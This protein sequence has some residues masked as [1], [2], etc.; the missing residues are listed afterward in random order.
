MLAFFDSV[1]PSPLAGQW[2]E[3]DPARLARAVDELLPQVPTSPGVIGLLAPHAGHRYSGPVAAQAYAALRG[4]TPQTVVILSP[5]HA[6]HSAPLLTSAHSAY[7][8]PLGQVP[9]EREFLLRLNAELQARGVP[10]LTP[11]AYDGEHAQEIQLPFLQRALASPFSLAPLMLRQYTPALMR[12]LGEI[13]AD[14]LRG[15]S[16][17]LIASSDLSHFYP[18]AQARALD[19]AM[20]QAV[21]SFDPQRVYAVAQQGKGEACGL[22]AITAVLWACR[23]LGAKTISRVGYGTSGDISGDTASVVGYGAALICL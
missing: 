6:Y 3:A 12:L 10:G 11:I 5:Y 4:Q 2:Y 13:L 17:L 8:T 9:V 19:E 22:G 21:E 18:Q 14:L 20:L 15:E 7:S 16:G 23:A 1:R